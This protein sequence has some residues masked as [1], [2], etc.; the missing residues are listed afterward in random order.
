MFIKPLDFVPIGDIEGYI[1]SLKVTGKEADDLREKHKCNR[2][3]K[4]TPTPPRKIR[5]YEEGFMNEDGKM[6]YPYLEALPYHKAMKPVP[7]EVKIRCMARCG[8][9]EKEL[10]KYMAKYDKF[11]SKEEQ[12][13][14][15]EEWVR[16]FGEP[17]K[18]KVLKVVKKAAPTFD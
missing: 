13:K 10:I 3:V 2:T 16:L 15:E 8:V 4:P 6:V 18:K 5:F 7:I 1:S 14:R 9:P 17:E 12:E 11:H